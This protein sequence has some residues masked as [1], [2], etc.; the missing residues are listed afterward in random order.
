MEA[1]KKMKSPLLSI[2]KIS[3]SIVGYQKQ[4]PLL[5]GKMTQYINFDNAAS[6]PA[7]KP[8][9]DKVNEAMEWYSSI[10]R[11]T[12]YK[13][14]LCSELYDQSRE[15]VAEFVKADIEKDAII[16]VK[17]AT[18]AINK[19]ANRLPIKSDEVVLV[20]KMEHH[21]NDLPWRA[22]ARVV[23]IN[24]FP[25]GQL[26]VQD[27][28]DKLKK[29]HNKVAL[30]AVTGAS[31]VTGWVNEVNQ[32]ARIC[33]EHGTKI[34]IDAAQLAPHRAID[35]RPHGDPGHIDFLALSAHKIYAPFG[36][37]ALI[38]PK[39]FFEDGDPDY[40]GGGTVNVVT[41]DYATWTESPEKDEAGT[42]NTIGVI[43]MAKSLQTLMDIGMD[44]IAEHE[45]Q[46]TRHM[47]TRMKEIPGIEIYGSADPEVVD[48]RLGVIALNVQGL[49][50]ALTAAILNYEGGVGVRNGCFCA[51]PYI[52]MLLQL[53]DETSKKLE[54]QM[55]EGDRSNLPGAVRA[56]F[57]LYNSIPEIDRFI[58]ILKKVVNGK[59]EGK[60]ILNKKE[61]AYYPEG[62]V[63]NFQN[64]LTI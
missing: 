53:D 55:L 44:K 22:N 9:L 48:N 13:S 14:Q 6:T 39:E 18:E 31:N 64:Y 47:L 26:D 49:P 61:G 63:Q 40:V 37:G 45:K 41:L 32:L 38:G 8:V 24:I 50:H 62:Y 29:Y 20:S 4:V 2:D 34:L 33:H 51:H 52:K 10:H 1:I 58:E 36:S 27:L 28:I 11:G 35:M 46:L 15:I 43:A 3:D 57:G 17:N 42:P 23:H 12:G 59:Y 60:Y 30:V 7:L 25:D 5:N 54:Q 56:S 16:F 19:L 21:S